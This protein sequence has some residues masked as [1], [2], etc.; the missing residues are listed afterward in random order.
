MSSRSLNPAAWLAKNAR[1]PLTPAPDKQ[2]G[3]V[4]LSRSRCRRMLVCRLLTAC[5]E[6][7]GAARHAQESGIGA[8]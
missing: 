7:I 4:V 3:S 2:K 1:A 6:T 8:A 5:K